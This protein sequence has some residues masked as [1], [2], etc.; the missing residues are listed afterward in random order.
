MSLV[1]AGLLVDLY[2]LFTHRSFAWPYSIRPIFW[3]MTL[4]ALGLV[5][6]PWVGSQ[7]FTVPGLV[8]HLTG[9][10]WLLANVIVPVWPTRLVRSPGIWHLVTSYV[11]ILAPVFIAP[12]IILNVPGFAGAGVEANVPQAL[13]YGW[14]LQFGY[15]LLPY[16]L[17]R[18]LLPDEEA[19]LGGNWFSL[20][21]VHLGG[22]LLWASIFAGDNQTLLHGV[23]YVFWV[24]SM[25]PMTVEVWRIVRRGVTRLDTNAPSL[26]SE[27]AGGH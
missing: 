15:A 17:R 18:A 26:A 21:T 22:V 14:V 9:T 2:P 6:G 25:L 8:L 23:A 1:F 19:R 12:L 24:L 5:L 7:W 10:L 13:I 16:L 27:R 20:M 3:L 4:G 11:W